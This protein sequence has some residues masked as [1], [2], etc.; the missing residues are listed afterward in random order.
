MLDWFFAWAYY[1][2]RDEA[3]QLLQELTG[4]VGDDEETPRNEGW[5]DDMFDEGE[6]SYTPAPCSPDD[7][8]PLGL[9]SNAVGPMQQP[10][11]SVQLTRTEDG[12]AVLV[13]ESMT[14]WYRA[15]AEQGATLP[16]R[17]DEPWTVDVYAEPVG[18][19]GR[20]RRSTDS[21]IWHSGPAHCHDPGWN[22][23]LLRPGQRVITVEEI[24][25]ETPAA[26]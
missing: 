18:H 14:G 23:F 11:G 7:D 13:V 26:D 1:A 17:N 2:P 24:R 12:R 25:G 19:L 4:F 9:M 3:L 8:D 22:Y 6:L 16:E 5:I 10:D 21:G 20:F 15:L